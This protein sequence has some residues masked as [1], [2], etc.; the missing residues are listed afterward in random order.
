MIRI[1]FEV[2]MVTIKIEKKLDCV[3]FFV[4]AV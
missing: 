1:Y 3:F 4:V 2:L